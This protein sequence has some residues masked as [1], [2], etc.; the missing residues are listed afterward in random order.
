MSFEKGIRRG[1]VWE[2][3]IILDALIK[4]TRFALTG[5]YERDYEFAFTQTVTANAER[6]KGQVI[7]QTNQETSVR[8]VY[9][10]GKRHR[11]DL[12]INE[13]GIAFEIKFL[14]E[15]LDGIKL[16]IGQS[17]LYRL[18]YKFVI[19]LFIIAERH[20]DTYA[21]ACNGEERDLEDILKDMSNEM[22]IFSYIVPAFSLAPNLKS[23]IENNGIA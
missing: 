6:I 15:S 3:V 12:T 22:N 14:G 7:S 4:K 13:D 20:K 8:S 23:C 1:S 5:K 21:K 11:P 16:A 9:C 17:M 10:F 2:D 19:N 18:R